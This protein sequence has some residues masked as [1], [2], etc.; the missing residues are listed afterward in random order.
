M[1]T[2]LIKKNYSSLLFPKTFLNFK[3]KTMSLNKKNLNYLPKAHFNHVKE[4]EKK[5]TFQEVKEIIYKYLSMQHREIEKLPSEYH[6]FEANLLNLEYPEE[7]HD[8]A[9][10][11]KGCNPCVWEI[12]DKNLQQF[13]DIVKYILQILNNE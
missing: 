13:E 5:Y 1:F 10:C 6:K 3:N 2:C 4:K 9:C 12:Y 11:G 7:P 8:Y